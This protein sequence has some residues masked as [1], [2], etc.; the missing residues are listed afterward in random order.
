MFNKR[1]INNDKVDLLNSNSQKKLKISPQDPFLARLSNYNLDYLDDPT[2]HLKEIYDPNSKWFSKL[3]KPKFDV[4]SQLPYKIESHKDQAT[5]L[6]HI[7]YNL[8]IA[9]SSLD[10]QGLLSISAKD[11]TGL[12]NQIND[13]NNDIDLISNND[14]AN[15]D[16]GEDDED[17][18]LDESNEYL[19]LSAPD[20]VPIGKITEESS[21]IINVNHWTNELKNCL[22]FN[23]PLSLRKSLVTVYYHLALVQGQKIYR[24][25]HVEVLDGLLYN[26]DKGNNYVAMLK[27]DGLILNHELIFQFL[28]EFL[29]YPDSDYVR[30]DV[31]SKEDL[32]LFRLLLKIAHISKQFFDRENED[33]LTNSMDFLLSSF[34]PS[35]MSSVLPIITSFMPY[36]YNTKKKITDYFP[37]MFSIWSSVSANIVIDTHMYDF[38]GSIS[39]DIHFNQ[40]QNTID[41][42]VVNNLFSEYGLFTRE[43]M[44][45]LFNR[46]Q[47]HLRTNGQIHSYSRTV[48]PFVYSINGSDY[49]FFFENLVSLTKSI[50]TFVHP[51]NSGFWT[52]PI[53]KFIHSFIKIYH[54]RVKLEQKYNFKS[55]IALNSDCNDK[56]VETFLDL[57]NIGAQNKNTDISNYYISCFAYLLDLEPTNKYLV[58]DKILTD[59]YDALSGEY[60]NSRHR[61]IAS[62]KQFN[63]VVRFLV[64]DKLYRVHV[65][66]ILSTFVEKI[67]LND[68]NLTSN[69]I[70]GIVSI[71][72]FI[73]L[74][75]PVQD[76]EYLSFESHTLPFIE[77]HFY[78][79]KS[80][81]SSETF[82]YDD[83][84]LESAFRASTTIFNHI[85]KAYIDK[86]FLLADIELDDGFITKV[87]QTTMIMI[88]SLD[89]KAFNYVSDLLQRSFWE[90]DAFKDKDANYEIVTIPLAALVKRNKFLSKKIFE[91]LIFNI[92]DQVS[93][94]AGSI[95]SSTE[96]QKRDTK[97]VLYLT[98]LNDVLRQSHDSI[99]E[100]KKELLEFMKYIYENITNPPLDVITSLIIHNVLLTLTSTEITEFRLFE[101]DCQLTLDSKWGGLQFDNIEKYKPRNLNFKWH[102]P[103][104]HEIEL[105]IEILETISSYCIDKVEKLLQSPQA[106]TYFVDSIQKFVLILTHS[107]SGSSLLYDPDYNRHKMSIVN[108][109]K[110]IGAPHN[111][112]LRILKDLKFINYDEDDLVDTKKNEDIEESID[113]KVSH[114]NHDEIELKEYEE[115]EENLIFEND[116]DSGE[117][118]SGSASRLC[119]PS[120]TENGHFSPH[121]SIHATTGLTDLNIFSC[122]Y[123]FGNEIEQKFQN[124]LYVKVHSIRSNIGSF[125]HKMSQFLSRNYEHNANI[126]QSLLHGL[127]VWFSDVGQENTFNDDPGAFLDLD[128]LENIQSLAHLEDPHT[129]TLLA[130]RVDNVHQSRV[131]LHSTSRRG[132]K[133]ENILLRDIIKLSCSVYPNIHKPAQGALVHCMKHIT[134]SYTLIVSSILKL[135]KENVKL[136]ENMQIKVLL[137]LLLIKKINRK[138]MSDVKNLEELCLTLIE[139][140]RINELDISLFA[141]KI[142]TDIASGLKIPSSICVHNEKMFIPIQPPDEKIDLQVQTVKFAK[143]QKRKQYLDLLDS[144][145]AGLL[146]VLQNEKSLSW[147]IPIIIIKFIARI[148]SSLETTTRAKTIAAIF[149]QSKARHP[150]IVHL[151][152]RSFLAI[153][154]KVFSLSDYGYDISRAYQTSYDPPFVTEIDT[155][156]PASTQLF[157]K[158]MNNFKSP[159]Y[160]IDSRGCVGWLCWGRKLKVVKSSR[161]EINL[162]VNEVEAV[163]CIGNLVSLEW[164]E[165]MMTTLVQDNETRS[166]FSSGD[167][168][169]FTF[170]IILISKKYT[171][172]LTLEDLFKLCEK[173]YDRDDKASMI[174]SIEI[175]SAFICASKYMNKEELKKRDVFAENFLQNALDHGFNHDAFEI[176]STVCWWL[177]TIV[178][179]RRFEPFYRIISQIDN[180]SDITSDAA[181]Q[182][183][184]RNLM[185]RSLLM[186]LEFKSPSTEEISKNLPFE[187]PYDQVRSSIAKLFSTLVQNECY[188]SFKNSEELMNLEITNVDGLGLPMK[189]ASPGIDSTIRK[190]FHEITQEYDK[191]KH[192]SPQEILKTRY[193]YISSTIFYWVKD[194]IKGPNKIIII[195]YLVDY[196]IP[197]LTTLTLQKDLCKLSGIDPASIYLGIAYLPIRKEQ[198]KP[199]VDSITEVS[200][201]TTSYGL[202]LRLA[203]V[204]HFLSSQLLQLTTEQKS[205]ILQFV[206]DQVY[207]D[208]YV[209]V[210]I[211]AADVLSDI[212]HNIDDSQELETLIENFS[213]KLKGYTWEEKQKLS[214]T[215]MEI[216]GSVVGLGAVISAFPYVFPLPKWIPKE[217]SEL[218]SWARTSGMAGTSAKDTISEFKKVRADT[219]KFDR[220]EFTS[221]QL[222]DLQ[223]VLWRSYYA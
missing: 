187:H 176:W 163:K 162:E 96:I 203:F 10:I 157:R 24:Q 75:C 79:L 65:T 173:F 19:D 152:L 144:L 172:N 181:A 198:I 133:L 222:E 178:D 34:A 138:L 26:D 112:K 122:N 64:M 135:L 29:P 214:K 160:F 46:L 147:K 56:I 59:V 108:S 216:H 143:E 164:L 77:Q 120:L 32:Q 31:Q 190:Q 221:D 175:F 87:N 104:K 38:V 116:D 22:H 51:S 159:S 145:E 102:V 63:R 84:V 41:I 100:Y 16:E 107:I 180:F 149:A 136:Q 13:L 28:C 161:V 68:I 53:A 115:V 169:F 70:N 146:I 192:L 54:G 223:G 137:K 125:F 106:N 3:K 105:A 183:A 4:L 48:K 117:S 217:L 43:Q 168:S 189:S 199:I 101:K 25:L 215:S 94:G 140:C 124:P 76:K 92:K 179:I 90:N 153:F 213:A 131:L 206:V 130:V 83:N 103:S 27:K 93:R 204:Q 97:L 158:E 119:T 193:Y 52:K 202:K 80:G 197:F 36:H 208:N 17:E 95:R 60:I 170:M 5:F 37:F 66:N 132:S 2:L 185:L 15:F 109:N 12:K 61:I 114:D 58:M 47:G 127:K 151:A 67:D 123:Y 49:G 154:N 211:R 139:C 110:S 20:F 129:R 121:T 165:N 188:P 201:D 219:W 167:V 91:A 220:L 1:K 6:C 72:S 99:F 212:A 148:Q 155:S 207:N 69:I 42:A 89:D 98:A 23:I 209:E 141:E 33:I 218:S 182:Q 184:Q 30:Y 7:I 62:L 88:E 21:A 156:S 128:F 9:I 150:D 44:V 113:S 111:E 200:N 57:L 134:G 78:H 74:E 194:M 55:P 8:Y 85:L 45:F 186:G 126:Y 11:L 14:I 81:K 191:V 196:I 86:L 118:I 142:I 82:E 39:E 195:P 35:T 50:K 174:M 18:D 40:L 171:K 73:P 166:V 205:Q 210:R 71:A 177:P